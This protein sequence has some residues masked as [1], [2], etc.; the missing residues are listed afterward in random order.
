M[1]LPDTVQEQVNEA[2]DLR[3]DGIIVYVDQGV[4][5]PA[6]YAAGWKNKENKIP[7][8]PQ[9]LFKIVSISKLY[10]AVAVAKL[11]NSGQLTLDKTLAEYLWLYRSDHARYI[12]QMV[13]L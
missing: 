13:P 4:K 6:F 11:V 9:S 7:A 12:G 5:G 1:P 3:L 2:I 10:V 8:D